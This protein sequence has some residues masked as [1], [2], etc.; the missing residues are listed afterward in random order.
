MTDLSLSKHMAFITTSPCY[1]TPSS[2]HPLLGAKSVVYS[3]EK[4]P[5]PTQPKVT[6]PSRPSVLFQ[7]GTSL[8]TQAQITQLTDT[9]TRLQDELKHVMRKQDKYKHMSMMCKEEARVRAEEAHV[10]AEAAR[11]HINTLECELSAFR[12]AEA[13]RFARLTDL[14]HRQA[15][16][17]AARDIPELAGRDFSR[18][19]TA[20]LQSLIETLQVTVPVTP[21]A[22]P[23]STGLTTADKASIAEMI[24]QAFQANSQ[25]AAPPMRTARIDPATR[26]PVS[27]LRPVSASAS[28]ELCDVLQATVPT[29]AIPTAV[30]DA[31]VSICK[32]AVNTAPEVHHAANALLYCWHNSNAI[33][34]DAFKGCMSALADYLGADVAA[35]GDYAAYFHKKIGNASDAKAK[36]MLDELIEAITTA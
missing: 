32:G 29:G 8:A 10:R 27:T 22:T 5:P 3:P 31:M 24:A 13:D 28:T 9:V 33:P 23:V 14:A 12:A 17:T 30:V 26:T 7:T 18:L 21:V 6:A 35:A 4:V 2:N 16:L 20:E 1:G 25:A 19:T 36:E 11:M 15:L 34:A